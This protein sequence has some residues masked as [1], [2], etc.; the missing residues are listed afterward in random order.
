MI[1]GG[2]CGIF[3]SYAYRMV[4]KPYLKKGDEKIEDM[5]SFSLRPPKIDVNELKKDLEDK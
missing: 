1:W 2:L 5:I 3:S 4:L